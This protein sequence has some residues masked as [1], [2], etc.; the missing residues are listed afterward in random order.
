MVELHILL[1]AVVGMVFVVVEMLERL[2][3]VVVDEM[4]VRL[5]IVV[6]IVWVVHVGPFRV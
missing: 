2:V 1:V 3:I 6:V 5:V 4:L